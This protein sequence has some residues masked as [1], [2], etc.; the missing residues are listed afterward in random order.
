MATKKKKAG[1]S[2]KGAAKGSVKK[3]GANKAA[4]DK[5]AAA[6]SAGLKK[7]V[8]KVAKQPRAALKTVKKMAKRVA[9]GA[10]LGALAGAVEG[11]VAEH[12]T[13]ADELSVG[14]LEPHPDHARGPVEAG[15]LAGLHVAGHQRPVVGAAHP[16]GHQ[17]WVGEGLEHL[18]DGGQ[19]RLAAHDHDR[20]V[21]ADVAAGDQR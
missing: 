11:D 2:K 16:A 6:N 8:K 7:T 10:A 3:G 20:V 18:A 4:A 21:L 1:K 19:S 5:A 14:E 12:V 17:V 15:R 13:R 9:Q